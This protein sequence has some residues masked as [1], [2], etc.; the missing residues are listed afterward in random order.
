MSFDL[1]KYLSEGKLQNE[2]SNFEAGHSD[3]MKEL[4]SKL[5]YLV[6][7]DYHADVYMNDNIKSA[8]DALVDAIKDEQ[9]NPTI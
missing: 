4:I 1:K 8:F 3:R 9:V 5:D 2:Q 6:Y 7:D